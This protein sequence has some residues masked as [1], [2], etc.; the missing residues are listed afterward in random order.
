M[1]D[2]A[3]VAEEKKFLEEHGYHITADANSYTVTHGELM[4]VLVKTEQFDGDPKRH[5]RV[6]RADTAKH[7]E[8]AVFAA[9]KHRHQTMGLNYPYRKDH[10]HGGETRR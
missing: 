7:L 8:L 6:K 9:R 5:W 10:K 4:G 2:A 1:R 3:G